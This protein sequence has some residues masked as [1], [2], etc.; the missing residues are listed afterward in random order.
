MGKKNKRKKTAKDIILDICLVVLLLVAAGS[1]AYIVRYY[2]VARTAQNNFDNLKDL[3]DDGQVSDGENDVK[4]TLPSGTDDKS[5]VTILKRFEKLYEKNSD[6]AGWLTIDG[7]TIDYPVMY[8]PEDNE[9]Y[10]HLDFDKNWSDPGTPFI[11]SHC[12]PFADRT[13]NVLIYGHNMKSGIMF[14]EL[15]QYQNEDFYKEHTTIEFD[16]LYE[17]GTYEV[18]A[19]FKAQIYADGDVDHYHYYEFFNA[20]NKEEFDEYVNFAKS[21]TAYTIEESAQ[22]GDELITL[23]TCSSHT[24]EGR[25]VVVAKKVK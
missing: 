11:D 5:S 19:A 17:L 21:N 16:T 23:S 18:I 12:R 3:M 25:F 15:L 4:I 10:L 7:T 9:Y 6:L 13:S 8:T 14:R 20:D 1:G 24:D 2:Y 22:Y